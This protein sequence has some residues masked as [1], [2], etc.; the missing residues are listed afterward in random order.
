MTTKEGRA[1][2]WQATGGHALVIQRP[3]LVLNDGSYKNSR[4]TP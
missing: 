4:G 2:V 1:Q 3:V